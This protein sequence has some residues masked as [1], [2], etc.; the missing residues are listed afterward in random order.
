VHKYKDRVTPCIRSRNWYIAFTKP[1]VEKTSTNI[2]CLGPGDN[3]MT[4]GYCGNESL[5]FG[6]MDKYLV[7]T[8]DEE[9]AKS[10]Q[11][12]RHSHLRIL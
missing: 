1:E 2:G 7:A 9:A 5:A 4:T 6:K 12:R 11:K 10:F 8:V 3:G